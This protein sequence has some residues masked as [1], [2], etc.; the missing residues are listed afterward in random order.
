MIRL[1][2]EEPASYVS[3]AMCKDGLQDYVD[4]WN[5]LN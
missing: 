2:R 5:E 1:A 3:F 4:A